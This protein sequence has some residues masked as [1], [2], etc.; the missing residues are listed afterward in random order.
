MLNLNLW[1]LIMLGQFGINFQ[2]DCV[3]VSDTP[4]LTKIEC[5]L[6]NG[7]VLPVEIERSLRETREPSRSRPIR[8]RR[9]S[10]AKGQR[11]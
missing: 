10:R 9:S 7:E 1:L 6:P 4:E 3:V 2:T 5:V 8:S 11:R